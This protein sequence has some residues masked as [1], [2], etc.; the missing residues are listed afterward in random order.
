MR[1]VSL[2]AS[3]TEIVSGLGYGHWLV[4]RSHECDNPHEVLTLPAITTPKFKLT[5]DSR[6]ID[7]QV[8]AVVA[9]GLAVYHVDPEA[10]ERL[11]PDLIVTQDQ[12]EVCAV[13]LADVERAVCQWTGAQARIVSLK[14]DCLADV[15]ATFGVSLWPSA[16]WRPAKR[17]S[18]GCAAES[19]P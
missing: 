11:K 13:S 7:R 2:I 6:D 9:D 16:M 8:K 4:A 19:P 3:A 14:P 10:L 18:A 17:W 15:E 1:V 5:G 12:C